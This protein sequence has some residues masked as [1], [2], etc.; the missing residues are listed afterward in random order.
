MQN[1][2][3]YHQVEVGYITINFVINNYLLF[4]VWLIVTI[5]SQINST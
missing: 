2:P 1:C 3:I 4:L 5:R